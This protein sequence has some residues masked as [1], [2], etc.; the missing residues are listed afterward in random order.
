[1]RRYAWFVL[2]VSCSPILS[3]ALPQVRGALGR[4]PLR[5]ETAAD[6][7]LVARDGPF[8]LTVEAG[9]SA[10]TITDRASSRSA[11]VTTKLAGASRAALPAGADP[12]EAKASYLLGSDPAAWRS[13]AA[14]F[15]RAVY[16]DVYP[17]I[18]LV[19]HGDSGALEYDFILR[20]GASPRSI[21][22]EVSGASGLMLEPGGTLAISTPAGDIR[23]KKPEIYQWRNGARQPVAGAFV[24]EGHRVSFKIGSY[25]R[26]RDMVID[27]T[28]S[29]ATYEGGTDNEGLRGVAV[30]AAGNFYVT[31]FTYSLNLP[32]TGGS[33]QPA[34]RGPSGGKI[35]GGDAFVAKYTAA[36]A[37]SYVTYLGGSGEDCG[38][39]ISVDA[40]GNVYVTGFTT[41]TDFPTVAGSFQTK[42]GGSGFG[43]SGGFF[44][45]LGDA[46][47]AKLNPAGTALVYST[48]LG[49]AADDQG[50]AIVVDSSGNA[51]VGGTTLSGN[52]PTKNPH[53]AVFGG[54]GGMPAFW[55]GAS[56]MN[57]GDG[58]VAKLNPAGSGLVFSTYFGG[59]FDDT[60]SALALDG[61]G[62]VYIGG[63]TLS[64]R[65]PVLN[66]FQTAFRGAA[67][68][69]SQPVIATGDGYAAK[70]DNTGKLVYSTYL[71]GSGD[72]AVLG[73]AVD[74][75]GA[76][77]ATGFTSSANFPV[78]AN[79]AQ[80]TLS[81]PTSVAGQRGFVWGDAFVAKIAP[82]GASLAWATYLGGSQDDAGMAIAIDAGGNPI[83][84]G[85]AN[86]TDLA[87]TSNALQSKFAGNG[88]AGFTDPTGDAFLAK[89][90]ADGASFQYLSYYGGN[91]SDAITALALDGRGNVIAGGATTSGNLPS[92]SNAAQ[93]VFGGQS[94]A[95]ATETMG[96]AFVAVFAGIASLPTVPTI[97]SV[98]NSA[99]FTTALAPGSVASIYGANLA[100][101]ASAGAFVGGQTAR[102]VMASAAQWNV[103]IPD[104]APIG[105][106]TIQAGGAAPFPITIAQYAPALFSADSLGRG[107]ILA[108]RASA[109]G[110][111]QITAS[112]T[113]FPGDQ[114]SV[115]VTGLGAAGA[116]GDA[117][118]LPTVTVNGQPVTVL[119]A[120]M[121]ASSPGVYT[122]KIQL[123]TLDPGNVPV[124]VS[125][126]GVNSQS[127]MLPV[128]QLTG[129][130]IAEV[131]NG[132]SFLPGF[133]QGSWITVKGVKLSGTT[134]IWTGADF[135]GPNLPTQLDGVGVTVNGKP[136]Y[137]YYIS[138]TQINALAPADAGDGPGSCR[139]H[140]RREH[141]QSF[142][143][144]GIRVLSPA[145]SCS[146]YR[147]GNT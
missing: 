65:F 79:A 95:M 64:R 6:G 109:G 117:G 114:I 43:G 126:G 28:L 55:N 13:G 40:G 89:V 57:F 74:A 86:S 91:S 47:V 9:Q 1:M 20:P 103:V 44:E 87:V 144:F 113:A 2:L 63:N 66:G 62:N 99:S 56:F 80:K 61:G 132:T 94:S 67:G 116:T 139:G 59:E 36:G 51:Y 120:N 134:R 25:D 81:G 26:N 102:V 68:S 45:A 143:R 131:V 119:S 98:V 42:F 11:T 15:S 4:F 23:W 147:A 52:F 106:T 19:F 34:Y 31:G 108:T 41:S 110:T 96:D 133:S 71:G 137:I 127:L 88:P 50:T 10:V 145:C 104:N 24:V 5:F 140:L 70:F 16:R 97:T 33:L 115:F 77:Y 27:P 128:G 107:V 124:V 3:A 38:E 14:L 17:G 84:G 18:D 32:H 83:A 141:D 129:F 30:D 135:N 138:P 112:A 12:L 76:A 75:A 78:S 125:A 93:A 48:Y 53:Q 130:G 39:A 100:A 72:D 92:T 49:G 136:A 123:A 8:R 46:F 54:L 58:F 122:V 118:V 22:L 101:S 85:F 21:A 7:R 82:S 73:L 69:S 111:T 90:S 35:V 121:P 37:L 142:L 29:Y 146:P 105:Q 60:V